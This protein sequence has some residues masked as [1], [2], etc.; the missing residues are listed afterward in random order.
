MIN[1]ETIKSI[2]AMT[3]SL[4]K[5]PSR[6]DQDSPD[7]IIGF[8]STW[9]A[10]H[11]LDTTR[12]YRDGRCVGVYAR[13]SS[14]SPGKSLC[15]DAPADTAP[16]GDAEQWESGPFSGIVSNRK[17]Y[18]RGAADAKFAVSLFSHL[19]VDLARSGIPKGNI[20]LLFDADEHT[21]GFAGV[22]QFLTEIA[23]RP[24]TVLVGYPGNYGIVIGA[25]GFWRAKV[26]THGVAEHSG[27]RKPAVTNALVKAAQLVT[28]LNELNMPH[29]EDRWFHFG[30]KVTVTT[31]HGGDSFTQIPGSCECHVDVR[32]TPSFDS[33][34][35]LSMLRAT[36]ESVDRAF[37][38]AKRTAIE[39]DE[40]WP[41]YRLDTASR[42]VRY[43][44]RVASEALGREICPVVCGPSNIGNYLATMGIETICGF[45]P[46]YE[47]IHAPNESV[48]LTSIASIYDIYKKVVIGYLEVSND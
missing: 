43:F 34:A 10:E 33:E 1:E 36:A 48:D 21:G 18:G 27:S 12:L 22:K 47:N 35:A 24:D 16:S 46:A 30:P 39:V 37:P 9:F 11:E 19:V 28:R 14:P 5:I 2:I 32:L 40:T 3:R 44:T 25:R 4:V 17:L 31:I 7:A 26:T 29:E 8:I 38:S 41:A 23:P 42:I 20:Y 6:A 15:L 13:I 45:G